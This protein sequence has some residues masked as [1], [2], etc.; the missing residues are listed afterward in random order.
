MGGGGDCSEA[1]SS[2]STSSSSF[3]LLQEEEVLL[4]HNLDDLLQFSSPNNNTQSDD[5]MGVKEV[6]GLDFCLGSSGSYDS[7]ILKMRRFKAYQQIMEN[8]NNLEDQ[9]GGLKEA[10]DMIISYKPG[11]WIEEV[12]GMDVSDYDIPKTT[13]LVLI[14][15]EGSGKS[16]LVNRIS[17]AIGENKFTSERAQ[18]SYNSSAGDGTYFLHEYMVPRGSTSFCLYDTR[19]LSEDS[20]DNSEMFKNWMINGVHH[21]QLVIRDSD[22]SSVK[23]KLNHKARGLGW[24]YGVRRRVGF[25]IFVVNGLSVLK[26]MEDEDNK[27]CTYMVAKTFSS[28]YLSFKDDKPVVVITHGDF[29]SHSNRARVRLHLGELLGIPPDTQIFDIPDNCDPS[30][31]LTI[32]DM[33]RYS[34][35]RAD[36]NLPHKLKVKPVSLMHKVLVDVFQV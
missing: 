22:A 28:P 8:Y 35:E 2:S 19:S 4:D 33:L 11:A 18:V 29:M 20:R 31:E 24:F 10:K 27:K 26:S 32:A 34:L 3:S 6:D 25:F 14:G 1:S 36:R 16:S 13:T 9:I 17:R 7:E 23:E 30:T 5:I 21:G 12:A 15:P